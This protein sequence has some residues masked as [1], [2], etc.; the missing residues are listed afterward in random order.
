MKRALFLAIMFFCS[1]FDTN[2]QTS[3]IPKLIKIGHYTQL[4]VNNKPYLI[5]GGELGNSSASSNDYMR[6]VWSK[7]KQMNLNTLIAP[8][9][10][11]L[12]EP[13]EGDFDF[14][15]VDSLIEDA[16][17]NHMKLVLLWFGSWKNS[18]SCYVPAWVKTDTK[19]FPRVLN[20]KGI[21]LE[22]LTPFNKNNLETDKDAFVRLMQ[23]L[24]QIDSK[25]YTVI[26]VQVEN[27][28][29]MLDNARSYDEAANAAFSQPIPKELIHY[30]QKN[31]LNLTPELDSIWAIAGFKT[32]GNWEDIFG[33]GLAT[34]EIFMAW[35]YSKY[36][37]EIAAAG[38]AVYDLPMYVNTAL[39]RAGWEPGQ[40]PSGGPEPHLRDIW[41]AGSPAIDMLAPDIYFPNFRHWT[42]LYTRSCAP[43]F[44]PEIRFEKDDAAKA[45]FAFGHYN[46]LSFSPF[47]IE[48]TL[49]PED[50][51]IGKAYN[52]LRQISPL[53]S[54]YQ[55][56]GDVNGFLLSKDSAYQTIT[57]G[58]YRLIIKHDYTLP[59]SSGSRDGKWPLGGCTIIE[60][61]PNE[62][63]IAGTGV[64]V[65]FATTTTG[66]R[67]GILSLDEG[68]FE[69]GKWVPG[70]RMNGDQDNQGRDIRIPINQWDIQRVKLYQY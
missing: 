47:S 14:S 2:A 24:K 12:M 3:S 35:N 69:N 58:E 63:Y 13:V 59:W 42:D 31:K 40:Y 15:L 23:H 68:S 57:M 41:K 20:K 4:L 27:E 22:I 62:F 21:P 11:E 5:L 65:T 52:I 49:H 45:I 28:I 25:Q 36:V 38:K 33:K 34:D 64:V 37:N 55:P 16:R 29:G 53:I 19:R 61:S 48:S 17:L 54:K 1:L 50:E 39:N 67:A 46:C 51:P 7:L 44:I 9:Y 56:E 10:W 43:L 8:V 60:V 32:S 66:K 6:S 18:M 30:L 26:A 70:R